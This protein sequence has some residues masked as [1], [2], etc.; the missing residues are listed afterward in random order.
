[1]ISS[2]KFA[3]LALGP[4][5]CKAST[6]CVDL[7]VATSVAARNNKTALDMDAMEEEISNR[8]IRFFSL[9]MSGLCDSSVNVQGGI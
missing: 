4:N 7:A 6:A 9:N 8:R 5:S 3:N 1:M 2:F